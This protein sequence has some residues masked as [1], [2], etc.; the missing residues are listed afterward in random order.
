M[1]RVLLSSKLAFV[2]YTPTVVY[3]V[4]RSGTFYLRDQSDDREFELTIEAGEEWSF[5]TYYAEGMFQMA[6]DGTIYTGEQDLYEASSPRELDNPL[7]D[8]EADE[9]LKLTCAN[10]NRG[11]ILM[12]EI[13]QNPFFGEPNIVD[14]GQAADL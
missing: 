9:W 7:K 10:G 3:V 13:S 6:Y 12:S 5:L 14:Y 11:W 2:S 4:N 1:R 8:T